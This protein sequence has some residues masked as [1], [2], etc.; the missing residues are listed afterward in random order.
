[1]KRYVDKKNLNAEIY[2]GTYG[3]LQYDDLHGISREMF[4]SS[5]KKKTKLHPKIPVPKIYYKIIVTDDDSGIVFIGVN[6]PHA[7]KEEINRNYIYCENVIETVD[8]IPWKDSLKMGYMY[9][10]SIDE[11][12]KFVSN[13]PNLP[14]VSRILL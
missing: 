10:C 6:N 9:A 12:K 14:K 5:S 1:M 13:S 8:Y 3:T 4:L 11:F 7:S 2:T